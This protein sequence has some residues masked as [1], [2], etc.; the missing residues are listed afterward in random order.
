MD[1]LRMMR[2]LVAIADTGNL[3]A[4]ARDW[5]VSPSTVTHG[6]KRLEEQL[7]AQLVVRTTRQLSLT[8]EGEAFRDRARRILADM[9]E[10]MRGLSDA[11]P[12]SG[13]IRVTAT[14]DLGRA[15]IAPLTD[16]FMRAHPGVTVQLFLGDS[17]VDL[18]EGGFDVGIR[19][20]PLQ[21]SDL[22][23]R[24]LLRGT[25]VVVAAPSYWNA[26]GRPE[27]PRDLERHNCLVL[28]TLTGQQAFWAFRAGDER[29]R[30]R[31]SGDRH[32]NDGMAL[33][34]WAVAGAGVALKSSFD[35]AA[36][37]AAGRLEPVLEGFTREATNLYAVSPPRA[38]EARRV[39][40]FL[41]H[42]S[43]GLEG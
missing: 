15:Q 21:D 27:H 17:L 12:L 29:F 38:Y 30:V 11:G 6:L 26:H 18:V 10:A 40:L 35:V 28:S 43:A 23:A 34:D 14:N 9:D 2:L 4:V 31:V 8:A 25:K 5:G 39:R 3:S 36:D 22:K 37:I 13:P 32:V 16:R 20:G 33:R 42:L 24:L 19:T 7:G 41:D 1:T